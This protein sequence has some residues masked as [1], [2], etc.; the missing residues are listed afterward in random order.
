ML[1]GL[2]RSL[3]PPRD[4]SEGE[5]KMGSN[6][7]S[8]RRVEPTDEWETIELLCGWPEQRDYELIRPLALFGSSAAERALETGA[9]SERTLQRG[10]A[11][12]EVEGMEKAKGPVKEKKEMPFAARRRHQYWSADIR[13]VDNDYIGGRAYVISVMDNHSRAIL[14]SAVSRT[15]DLASNLSVLCPAVGEED[16]SAEGPAPEPR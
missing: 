6:R 4:G 16:G 5:S 2:R 11:R 13:Y 7:R 14:A 12:F 3:K 10:V 1:P 9:T 15:Q 8:R